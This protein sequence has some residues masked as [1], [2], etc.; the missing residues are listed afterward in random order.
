MVFVILSQFFVVVGHSKNII[1]LQQRLS[2][3]DLFSLEEMQLG[4]C[5]SFNNLLSKTV[6]YLSLKSATAYLCLFISEVDGLLPVRPGSECCSV[7]TEE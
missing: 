3:P 2:Q 1:D 4:K 7:N 5:T 6:M